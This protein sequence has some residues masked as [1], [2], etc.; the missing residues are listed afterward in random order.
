MEG[1][2]APTEEKEAAII[3]TIKWMSGRA[4]RLN[5]KRP[6]GRPNAPTKVTGRR[7]TEAILPLPLNFGSTHRQ[8]SEVYG[9]TMKRTPSRMLQ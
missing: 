2:K 3:G 1:P 4:V 9:G 6:L 5:V 7:S 8:Y